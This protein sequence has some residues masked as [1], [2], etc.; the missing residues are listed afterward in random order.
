MDDLLG[1]DDDLARIWS[2][3]EERS[4]LLLGAR[5]VG[6]TEL[7]RA[8]ERQPRDGWVVLRVDVEGCASV[9]QGI[10]QIAAG[11][12]RVGLGPVVPEGGPSKASVSVAGV[13]LE[14]D[15]R[16]ITDPW[17]RLRSLL[18]SA[19]D[20]QDEGIVIA[21]DE[22]PWWLDHL[23]AAEPPAAARQVLGRLRQLR[24]AA[25]LQRVRWVLTGSVSLP[26]LAASMGASA[27]LNDLHPSM[28]LYPLHA[29]AGEALFEA[30]VAGA[31][32]TST[33]EARSRAQEVTGGF[34][35]WLKVLAEHATS[36][37]RG[38]VDADT[39][40]AAVDALLAPMNRPLFLDEGM[41][42]F[43]RRRPDAMPVY[44]ALL[45]HL[46]DGP[47]TEGA[48]V[49]VVLSLRPDMERRAAANHIYELVDSWHI[50]E[51]EG[52]YR[53]LLP[54]LGRWWARY[55]GAGG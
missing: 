48:L 42:H 30:E 31:H 49:G 46:C 36:S 13:G 1:R 47:A 9:E 54:L 55:G 20:K 53:F 19:L 35:H 2:L 41:E 43:H 24:Q 12:R 29:D 6:K 3:L 34:P 7:L 23:L 5:R 51:A 38:V 32:R 28:P 40:E 25:D 10:D 44:R 52:H 22:V 14:V 37:S 33:P 11:L 26:Q 50:T 16:A 45:D 27:D 15:N 17:L 18:G 39:I 4:V 21:L 8:M